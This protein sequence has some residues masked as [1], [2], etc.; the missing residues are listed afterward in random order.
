MCVLG[1]RVDRGWLE[2]VEGGREGRV[3]QDTTLPHELISYVSHQVYIFSFLAI[4]CQMANVFF[5]FPLS[6]LCYMSQV[7]KKTFF[8]PSF[9]RV[10][11][12]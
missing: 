6:T 11:I 2:R 9:T 1:L 5:S 7:A 4:I 10:S 8:A 12:C 3:G